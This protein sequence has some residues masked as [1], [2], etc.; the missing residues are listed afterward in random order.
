MNLPHSSLFISFRRNIQLICS[1]AGALIIHSPVVMKTGVRIETDD[2][3]NQKLARLCTMNGLF[4]EG[5]WN[6]Q[7]IDEL[8]PLEDEYILTGR[9]DFSA[10]E[11][12]ELK[13]LL[14]RN[15]VHT[16][17]MAGFLSNICI[18]ETAQAARDMLPGMKVVVIRECC[19]AQ[20]KDIHRNV[21]DY[22]LPI[23]IGCDVKTYSEAMHSMKSIAPSSDVLTA[24]TKA[25]T[26]N[27]IRVPA[28]N[29]ILANEIT[30]NLLP[31]KAHYRPRILAMHGARSN[32][33]ITRLQLENLG[34]T[35][36][37]YDIV[38]LRGG[39]E[40]EEGNEETAGLV[41]G[42]F[43]SWFVGDK[44]TDAFGRSI[45]EAVRDVLRVVVCHGPFDG[46]YAFSNGAAVAALAAGIANDPSL[47]DA[48]QTFEDES[49][50]VGLNGGVLRRLTGR[51]SAAPDRRLTADTRRSTAFRRATAVRP[52]QAHVHRG[53]SVVG[54]EKSIRRG[55]LFNQAGSLEA[56]D[57]GA[58]FFELTR[59]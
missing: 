45:I 9:N 25:S 1:E 7:F 18:Q 15:N 48:V 10:F 24:S 4:T 41:H 26:R 51:G 52:S 59:V 53:K 49:M 38:F 50:E 11:G 32:D 14:K 20:S 19:A 39:I 30:E 8:Q 6:C 55:T 22:T 16:L 56:G 28:R 54:R 13:D 35:Q 58:F 21:M 12:T 46:C 57:L 43:Y 3:D 37:D 34:I 17:Y 29:S 40:V 36:D 23:I 42:P 31:P 44:D 33:E 2:F 27:S 5:T 47:R